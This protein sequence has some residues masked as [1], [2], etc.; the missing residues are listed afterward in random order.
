MYI[1]VKYIGFGDRA[2]GYRMFA[3]LCGFR[4]GYRCCDGFGTDKQGLKPSF[5]STTT[6]L[7]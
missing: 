7:P 5:K 6:P 3:R 4:F 1:G 2:L